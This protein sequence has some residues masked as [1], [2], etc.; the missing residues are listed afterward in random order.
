M[1]RKLAYFFRGFL[2]TLFLRARGAKV[3]RRLRVEPGL[4]FREP[5]HS[6]IHVGH[7]VFMGVGC[8][9]DAPGNLTIGDGVGLTAWNYI[10]AINAVTIGS[11]TIIGERTSIRD[12]DHGVKLGRPMHTQPMQ[13]HPIHIGDDVWI[14]CNAVVLCGS[15]VGQGAVIG[16]NAVVKGIVE[17]YDIVAGVPARKI[18]TRR[19]EHTTA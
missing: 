3:G 14:G 7:D 13:A 11:D 5:P 19:L 9:L 2:W 15:T 1:L 10:S 12:A 8:I 18:G 17:P 16:A 4:Q 6:G